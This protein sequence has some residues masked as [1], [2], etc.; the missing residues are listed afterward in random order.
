MNFST[1]KTNTKRIAKLK[2]PPIVT[3]SG[4]NISVVQTLTINS[5]IISNISFMLRERSKKTNY[6]SNKNTTF[7]ESVNSLKSTNIYISLRIFIV[8]GGRD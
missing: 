4:P 7:K 2:I 5:Q 3:E 6:K 1:I 8:I